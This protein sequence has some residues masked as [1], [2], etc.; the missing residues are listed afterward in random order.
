VRLLLLT[1]LAAAVA[2][3]ADIGIVAGG[4]LS[5]GDDQNRAGHYAAG[6]A[7]GLS[8]FQ[9]DY[10]RAGPHFVTG[11]YRFGPATGRARPFLQLGAGGAFGRGDSSLAVVIGAGATIDLRR[12]LFI[13]PEVRLYGHVG[14]TLTVVP[15]VAFGWRF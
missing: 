4:G 14:P 11:S 1:L 8:R 15:L 7:A 10:L 5:M 3:P 13:R 9:L 6:V 2:Q 12:S